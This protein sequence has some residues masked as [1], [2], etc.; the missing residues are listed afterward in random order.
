MKPTELVLG[1]LLGCIGVDFTNILA[2]QR[3]AVTSVSAE[4]SS[5]QDP[6]PP[7]SFRR[8]EVVFRVGGDNLDQRA[9]ER[10]LALAAERYCAV[11]A[12]LAG[13][14]EITHRAIVC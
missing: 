10:A 8:I 4:A 7:W 12:T 9:V 14:V 11:G 5:E 1:A 6:Q 3:Q 13:C 2:K